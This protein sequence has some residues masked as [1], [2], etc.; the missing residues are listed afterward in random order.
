M[1]QHR[2][3][4]RR[5]LVELSLRHLVSLPHR[6]PHGV[7]DVRQFQSLEHRPSTVKQGRP[8]TIGGSCHA[9]RLLGTFRG[10]RSACTG[11]GFVDCANVARM[12]THPRLLVERV[13]KRP[14]HWPLSA[15]GAKRSRSRASP[16]G[17][18]T[19]HYSAARSFLIRSVS[20]S[21]RRS[22]LRLPSS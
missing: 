9:A 20:P 7:S 10:S 15:S 11:A 19:A 13:G 18:G 14:R 5:L 8:S 21:R 17:D 6:R 3:P 22:S 12:P 4:M 16:H 2:Q 1:A